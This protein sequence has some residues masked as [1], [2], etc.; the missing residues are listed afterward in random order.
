MGGGIIN[1]D[2]TVKF[3]KKLYDEAYYQAH[4]KHII[5]QKRIRRLSKKYGRLIPEY[6]ML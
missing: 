1:Y 5:E 2:Y 4:K 6:L 3:D